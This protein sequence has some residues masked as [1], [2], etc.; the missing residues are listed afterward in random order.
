MPKYEVTTAHDCGTGSLTVEAVSVADA[1]RIARGLCQF[2]HVSI[3]AVRK[4]G[5]T[6]SK[7]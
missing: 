5:D 3:V 1:R 4:I 2:A 7:P 6:H